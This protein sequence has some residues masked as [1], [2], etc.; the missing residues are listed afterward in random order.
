MAS[1][2]ATDKPSAES[3]VFPA[4]IAV[5]AVATAPDLARAIFNPRSTFLNSFQ[6]LSSALAAALDNAPPELARALWL[7]LRPTAFAVRH[8]ILTGATFEP[9][10]PH[11]FPLS[12]HVAGAL[13]ATRDELEPFENYLAVTGDDPVTA[14]Q[15]GLAF[16][17]ER[18]LAAP[19][20]IGDVRQVL[21]ICASGHQFETDRERPFAARPTSAPKCPVCHGHL[22]VAGY[23]SLAAVRPDIGSEFDL[24][25]NG[26]LTAEQISPGSKERYFWLCPDKGHSYEA[27]VSNRT[28]ANSRCPVCLNRL[29]I[30]GV[31]DL[32]T[33]HPLL[34]NEFH[35]SWL[36][37]VSPTAH[38]AGSCLIVRWVCPNGHEYSMSIVDRVNSKGCHE[39]VTGQ[40]HPSNE[41]LALTHPLIAAEW[42][43]TLNKGLTPDD[44][45]HGSDYTAYWLCPHGHRYRQRIERR[46]AGYK[47]SVCSRRTLVPNVNDLK[48]TQP[49]L[50]REFHPYLNGPT[51]PSR[52]FAGTKLYWWKCLAHG[53]VHNQSVLHRI[54]SNGC[55][56]CPPSERILAE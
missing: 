31:N 1:A 13:K 19:T 26:G 27:T 45:T 3:D 11:D 25:R 6:K 56:D 10:W 52:I 4:V 42:H 50:V 33:T 12:A 34:V 24:A 47:C 55:P 38:G 23:N 15:F 9:A 46:T 29:I 51:D 35:P 36:G 20:A 40:R 32:A 16:T 44:F 28:S 22:I 21:A 2:T 39:C 18:R 17:N 8:S 37:Q 7:Y 14:A 48:T 49:V 5:A 53:H 54:A 41:S 30:A 43:P